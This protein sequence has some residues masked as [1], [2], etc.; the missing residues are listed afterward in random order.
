MFSTTHKIERQIL[1][2]CPCPAKELGSVYEINCKDC[3][4]KYIGETARP[5]QKRKE[6][7]MRSVREM[8][9][10]RS[11]VAQHTTE[12]NHSM[13]F[14]NMKIIDR[15]ESKKSRIIKEAIWTKK[16]NGRNRTFYDL[17]NLWN[18]II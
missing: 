11:E 13:D 17:G 8:D 7:H 6:E 5:L 4:W 16:L 18:D 9:T 15:E 12:N 10:G 3:Q 2:K 14:E 1:K